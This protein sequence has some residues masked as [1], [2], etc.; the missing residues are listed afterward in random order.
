M[1]FVHPIRDLETARLIYRFYNKNYGMKKA[2]L[3]RIGCNCAL[4]FSD[5]R[6]LRYDQVH[7]YERNGE[8]VGQWKLIEQKTKKHKELP[9]NAVVMSVLKELRNAYPDDVYVFQS[10]GNNASS[11]PKPFSRQ[12]ISTLFKD[13]QET[14]ALVDNINTHTM[15]KTF[16]FLAYNYGNGVPVEYLQKLYNHSTPKETLTYLGITAEVVKDV[17]HDNPVMMV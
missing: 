10:E 1:A 6:R 7:S 9:L 15:R 3:W 12:Y 14:L 5:L 8:V 16:G 11:E 2:A 17:Y 13:A 4:R